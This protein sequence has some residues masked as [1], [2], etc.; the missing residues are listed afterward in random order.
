[1]NYRV[2]TAG[3]VALLLYVFAMVSWIPLGPGLVEVTR[4]EAG[5]TLVQGHGTHF[6]Q[7]PDELRAFAGTQDR[8]FPVEFE[9]LSDHRLLL[10]PVWPDTVHRRSLDLYLQSPIDGTVS[11]SNAFFIDAS[12]LDPDHHYPPVALMDGRSHLGFHFP[13]QPQIFETIRNLMLHVPMWFTMFFLMGISF[14]QSIKHLSAKAL[15][16]ADERAATAAGTGVFFGIIGLVTGSLWAR[17]TWG[18]WWVASDPQLNGA[19]VTVLVYAGYLVLR[20]AVDDPVL[21]ARISAVF[22]L[23]AFVLLII[24]LMIFPRFNESLHP[25]KGGNPGFNAYDLDSSLRAVF[26][27][28]VIGWVLLGVGMYRL[29]LQ[30]E[31]LKRR[32]NRLEP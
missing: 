15:G 18:D 11:L 8:L 3:G 5:Q 29:R 24:L 20:A 6:T 25:G 21:K 32:L 12:A 23:F 19:L 16:L 17:Y 7:S 4:N 9:I 10:F 13:F 27:P 1:M 31:S 22:N 2:F 26:Y 14:A 30:M 28:A